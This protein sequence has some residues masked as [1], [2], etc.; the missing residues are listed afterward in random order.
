MNV[1]IFVIII[2]VVYQQI[3]KS[4]VNGS[5]NQTKNKPGSTGGNKYDTPARYNFEV[6]E[7]QRRANPGGSI[8]NGAKVNSQHE[9]DYVHKV[10][11]IEKTT[12][13][14][15]HE[16]R[17]NEYRIK[18]EERDR[19]INSSSVKD[20]DG[21]Y[22]RDRFPAAKNGD[23]G[24]IAGQTEKMVVCGYCGAK[25]ILPR[26]NGGNRFS[27]YFCREQI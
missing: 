23:G 11:P 12:A 13:V 25:N 9:H 18:Q 26:Y 27:C 15:D 6:K 14:K 22:R 1:I 24:Q 3:K 21:G 17:Q 2:Y 16:V 20:E 4:A 19:R 8:S 7:Q 5:G 10:E